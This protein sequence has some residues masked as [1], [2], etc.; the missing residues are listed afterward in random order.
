MPRPPRPRPPEVGNIPAE[1]TACCFWLCW[2]FSE[3]PN[4]RGK[5]GKVPFGITDRERIWFSP[6][7]LLPQENPFTTAVEQP[8]VVA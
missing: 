7:C 1:L 2:R 4:S 3:T 5:F 8:E 6:Y